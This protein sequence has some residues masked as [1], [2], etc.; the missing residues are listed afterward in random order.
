MTAVEL[1]STLKARPRSASGAP[2]WTRRAL[3]TTVAPFPTPKTAAKA[4]A[5]QTS[6]EIAASAVPSA[7]VASEK[8]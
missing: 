2:R 6:G 8:A 7:I 3:Q 4:A 1:M 5:T